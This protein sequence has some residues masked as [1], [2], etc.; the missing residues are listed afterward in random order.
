[1]KT[2]VITGG[3]SGIGKETA[4]GLA[5]RGARVVIASR[6][7]AKGQAAVSEIRAR[8]GSEIV[9]MRALDLASFASV[10]TFAAELLGGYE[11]IDVLVNNAGV[12]LR[13]REVTTDGHEMTFQVNHLGPF[14]LTALLRDRIVASA[15]ARIV[16]TASHAHKYAGKGIDFDDLDS[17]KKYPPFKV[18]GRTKLM[19]ILFTRELARRLD[20]T[21][22]TANAVHPGY[23]ASNFAREGDTGKLGNV[24]MVLGRPFAISAAKGAETTI[25]VASSPEVEGVTGQD[26]Y[27]SAFAKESAAAQ[28]DAAAARLWEISEQLTNA[29]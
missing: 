26:F 12:V 4:V 11:R 17:E 9:E 20:G 18:Y 5:Q 14:L 10:R 19:N 13:H 3:N 8:S 1:V 15:P 16:M 7:A 23:V 6:N 25:Y 22:V 21:N 28:E 29:G 24:A 27:K 2:V